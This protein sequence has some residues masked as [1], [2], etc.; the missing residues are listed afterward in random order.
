MTSSDLI[1]P[2]HLARRAVVYIRQSSPQQVI[3]H[4]ESLRL[5]YDLKQRAV[6]FGWSESAIDIIDNDLGLT[7]RTTQGRAGFAELVSRVTLG[8][9]GI[10]FSYDVTRLSRNCSDWYQLLDLCGFRHCLIGDHDSIYDPSS[11]NG[12]MLLGLKG[13]ISELELHTIKA[14]LTAGLLNKARRGELP[15]SLPVGLIRD[16]SG[17]VVKH[18]DQ[19]VR[20]RIDFVFSTFLRVKSIHGV[21]REF[22]GARL[23][24]PRRQ[25]GRDDG[26]IVWRRPT[27]AAL[28]SLLRNP[29]YAGTFVYGRTRFLPRVSGGPSRKH[30]LP[31]EEWRFMVPDKYPAYID[32]DTF[33]T[34]QAMLRDNYQE[35]NRRRSRGVARSGAAL[36][37]GLVYCGHC[38]H[39]MTVQYHA[40]PRYLCNTHKVQMGG[41]ECQRIP[42]T[43]VDS[44][45]VESFWDALSPAELEHYD[46]AVA[47][48]DERRR[49]VRRA[50]HLELKRLRYEARLAEKQYQLV[51][52]ENRLV[53]SELE[54]RWEQALQALQQAEE[55]SQ[56]AEATIEP[57][58]DELRRQL[59]EVRPSL[60]QLWDD[61]AMS[62]ARKKELLRVLID[63]VVLQ[64]P[65]GD[66]C[67][68]RIVW[69]GGDWTTTAIDLPVVTY[70]EM[71]TSDEL[72]A[73]VLRRARLGQSDR[74]IAAELTAAGYHAPLKR[75]L[76]TASV[77]RIR[78][79]HRVYSHRTEFQRHGVPGWIS[80]GEAAKRLDEHTSWAY[81]L[82]RERRLVMQ[83]DPE[84][85]LYLVP[86]RKG[87]LRQLKD[88]FRGKRFSLTIEPR[89]S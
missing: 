14:R 82:I 30:P 28:S 22:S 64:R 53:A 18:P 61:G 4:Q 63:K 11:I 7:A 20:E 45:V 65:A 24:I 81:Y 86:D 47:A 21:V 33:A 75:E 66:K 27:A 39:K 74:Q 68:A 10:I 23:L 17:R 2:A 5:Q 72:I 36:L 44:W 31:P 42:I 1:T 60:R 40:A 6:S 70:A 57:M 77:S 3:S 46:A 29:A 38:G 49:E 16:L 41:K 52:P 89:L 35:Y 15:Q 13:Q 73:E 62:N 87:V 37:Q 54:R 8:D 34:I 51:D 84:I 19:E 71:S 83:R 56:V 50:H 12:R 78:W 76:N 25:R 67:D 88:L 26:M 58:T 43:P 48:L 32:R 79:Q 9:V 80:L 85:G 59:N 69:K 55:A